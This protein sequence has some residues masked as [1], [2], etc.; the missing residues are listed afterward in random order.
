MSDENK[1]NLNAIVSDIG[2]KNNVAQ[3][4]PSVVPA[5]TQS[6][7]QK[8]KEKVF[9]YHNPSKLA[10]ARIDNHQFPDSQKGTEGQDTDSAEAKTKERKIRSIQANNL[11]PRPGDGTKDKSL[12]T[13]AAGVFNERKA[14]KER[15]KSWDNESEDVKDKLPKSESMTKSEKHDDDENH[16]HSSLK[17]A[18]ISAKHSNEGHV[19]LKDNHLV[20][21]GLNGKYIL[22]HFDEKA[23]AHE[24]TD[25]AESKDMKG[26]VDH[27]KNKRAHLLNDKL[28]KS[29]ISNLSLMKAR[30]D[31]YRAESFRKKGGK[32]PA[33]E[34]ITE[35]AIRAR[36]HNDRDNRNHDRSEKGVNQPYHDKKITN[37]PKLDVKE[38][39]M[40]ESGLKNR[41]KNIAT[42]PEAK[43]QFKI[44]GIK[45]QLNSLREQR[46]IKPNLPKSE[47]MN[48]LNLMKARVDEGKSKEEKKKNRWDR[49]VQASYI[50]DEVIAGGDSIKDRFDRNSGEGHHTAIE[51]TGIETYSKINHSKKNRPNLPK[52]EPMTKADKELKLGLPKPKVSI[53][54][55]TPKST[56]SDKVKFIDKTAVKDTVGKVKG[57]LGFS[58]EKK[59]AKPAFQSVGHK[60]YLESLGKMPIIKP[61]EDKVIKN[62][63]LVKA[64][65]YDEHVNKEA[66][67]DGKQ[68]KENKVHARELR[69]NRVEGS[70]KDEGRTFGTP[71]NPKGVQLSREK[72]S[73]ESG[74]GELVREKKMIPTAKKIHEKVL[75]ESKNIKPNLPKSE[76]MMK[77]RVDEGKTRNEKT[78]AR[79]ER[80]D[81]VVFGDPE[82]ER[83]NTTGYPKKEIKGVH[84]KDW[85]DVKGYK[86]GESTMG[87][88]ARKGHLDSAK[89]IS[90]EISGAAKEIKPKLPK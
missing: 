49:Q 2:D 86:D 28:K 84:K 77:A 9:E 68:A 81:R 5:P 88:Q 79:K 4:D 18:G 71:K 44:D 41:M 26:I 82:A 23:G 46:N 38:K 53:V 58:G 10:K 15:E 64:N 17:N 63:K 45:S 43:A 67:V 62:E 65:K 52:S 48:R 32:T 11:Y 3:V 12:T 74:V 37:D 80:N 59:T 56:L 85:N 83:R 35:L 39:G 42:S 57:E 76:S 30:I 78:S 22:A 72:N 1:N 29:E 89:K 34:G 73:G 69:N 60:S 87:K 51:A 31:D 21:K 25:L 24:P 16:I 13:R 75:E 27:I 36:K 66:N 54:D 6:Q 90:A 61:V 50:P 20:T 47:A 8:T 19:H 55:N 14:T 33:D 7:L 40:S 70:F